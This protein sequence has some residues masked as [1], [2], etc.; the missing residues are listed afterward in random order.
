MSAKPLFVDYILT[1]EGLE[2]IWGSEL[3][4]A[5]E[6]GYPDFFDEMVYWVLWAEGG[7]I[8]YTASLTAHYFGK[9]RFAFVGNTY[10]RSEWRSKGLH[11][12]L[13]DKR[14]SA[15]HMKD[16]DK[17][18]ILNPIEGIEMAQLEKVVLSLGYFKI[19]SFNQ[20]KDIMG[21]R[22]YEGIQNHSI[23]RI[24]RDSRENEEE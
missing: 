12:F 4:L 6:K 10:V 17:I 1:H 2:S 19:D 9:E 23:W 21:R 13:L 3:P 22:V 11:S 20:V 15:P 5:S 24:N 18:T 14:N 8:A 7:P 16:L